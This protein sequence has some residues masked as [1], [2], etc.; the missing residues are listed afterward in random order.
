MQPAGTG[1]RR[2]SGWAEISAFRRKL[3]QWFRKNARKLPWRG[4]NDPYRT[5]VS[6]VMLQQ[7][8]VTAVIEHYNE[9]LLRFPTVL[10]L[11][12]AREAGGAGG[13]VGAGV[14]PA[15]ADAAQDGAVHY[16][17]AAGCV[18]ADSAGLRTLPGIGEYTA[19]AIASIAFGES[20]A[21]VDG[22]VERVLLRVT[23]RPHVS[24][25]AGGRLCRRRR[26][27]WFREGR[28]RRV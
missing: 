26:A 27:R 10:A 25:A 23:G 28:W 22:N 7:T 11:S 6:E 14:L 1:G 3:M 5:W 8:R 19:A 20:I 24:T 12:L 21:V 13:V 15:G 18:A 4:V 17:G 2:E 9:F 16:A